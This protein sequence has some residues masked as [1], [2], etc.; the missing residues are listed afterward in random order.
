MAACFVDAVGSASHSARAAP[1]A[2]NAAGP[3]IPL[4]DSNAIGITSGKP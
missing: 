3:K 2:G 4:S 1:R